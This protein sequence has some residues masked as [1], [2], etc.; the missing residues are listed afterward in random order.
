L[1]RD[2]N[3]AGCYLAA[4]GLDIDPKGITQ[5]Y[6]LVLAILPTMKALQPQTF[7]TSARRC[8]AIQRPLVEPPGE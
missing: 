7:D 6:P 5:R 8:I 3:R 2:G 4:V 1:D